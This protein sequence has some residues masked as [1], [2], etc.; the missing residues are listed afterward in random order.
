MD[1]FDELEIETMA[2]AQIYET[3]D[4][5]GGEQDFD[6]YDNYGTVSGGSH[7]HHHC[8]SPQG[9]G[10]CLV[11]IASGFILSAAAAAAGALIWAF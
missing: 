1:D 9:E 4:N 7:H 6:E 8:N 10:G 5:C 2:A 3:D 11:L